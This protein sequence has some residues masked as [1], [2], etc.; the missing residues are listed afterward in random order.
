MGKSKRIFSL[1]MCLGGCL[2]LYA[3][4]NKGQDNQDTT[5]SQVTKDYDLLIYNTHKEIGEPF[6]KMCADYTSRTGVI[7]KSITTQEG[8]NAD[9][10][11]ESYMNSGE[12]PDIYTIDD[13][14]HLK[15]W[16]SSGSVLDFSNATEETFKEIDESILYDMAQLN[17]KNFSLDKMHLTNLYFNQIH[18]VRHLKIQ[19]NRLI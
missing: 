4:G 11:L 2:C 19:L 3:C 9:T 16:Q 12:A 10:E 14:S 7:L 17:L 6:E 8:E 5:K 18:Q 1:L 15:K 13:M